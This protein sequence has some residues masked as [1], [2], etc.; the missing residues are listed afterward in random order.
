MEVPEWNVTLMLR[1]P[2]AFDRSR[3][4]IKYAAAQ[5]DGAQVDMSYLYSEVIALCAVDPAT[6][7]PV[8]GNDQ[9]TLAALS[10]KNGAVVERVATRC[11]HLLGMGREDIDEKKG[12]S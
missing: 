6:D 7:E 9:G 8:F 10:R 1:S 5:K 3:M 12:G 4:Q 2:T 11:M